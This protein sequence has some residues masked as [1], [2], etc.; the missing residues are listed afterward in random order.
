MAKKIT[1]WKSTNGII[2]ESKQEAENIEAKWTTI[3]NQIALQITWDAPGAANGFSIFL[4]AKSTT[5]AFAY[6]RNKSTTKQT[7]V[8]T[9]Q[10]I[11]NNFASVFETSL[12]G[13]LK[14]IY[15]DTYAGAGVTFNI[16][17]FIDPLDGATIV[18]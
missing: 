16:P 17:V 15:I 7:A 3:N 2:Y 14:S 1:A 10:D 8:I 6:S 18:G 5:V 13:L 9:A 4:S 12:T 11:R